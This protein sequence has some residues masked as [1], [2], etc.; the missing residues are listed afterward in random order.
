M[1][2][3]DRGRKS[4]LLTVPEF[5]KLLGVGETGS[6]TLECLEIVDH[7]GSQGQKYFGR[8]ATLGSWIW[9]A[10]RQHLD[11][12][13]RRSKTVLRTEGAIEKATKRRDY[14]RAQIELFKAGCRLA[15][16]RAEEQ[17]STCYRRLEELGLL[18]VERW[19]DNRGHSHVRMRSHPGVLKRDPEK[20]DVDKLP[21]ETND[22]GRSKP[23]DESAQTFR[24]RPEHFDDRKRRQRMWSI[25]SGI[26][27]ILEGEKSKATARRKAAQAPNP[28]SGYVPNPGSGDT[29]SRV[30]L[31]ANPG[32]NTFTNPYQTPVSKTVPAPLRGAAPSFAYPE[33]KPKDQ[34]STDVIVFERIKI[35]TDLTPNQMLTELGDV[36]G[37]LEGPDFEFTEHRGVLLVRRGLEH[38]V[39]ETLYN[40][41]PDL[42][43]FT[44]LHE[45]RVLVSR[46]HRA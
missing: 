7:M 30:G 26:V 11:S 19:K 34:D 21:L 3:A 1:P 12:L 36:C 45:G 35:P 16:G 37:F 41:P 15:R 5:S 44:V 43:S 6:R 31:G 8:L 2:P 23:W 38:E 24:R 22:R 25:P 32:S 13:L 14:Y 17:A 33:G 46:E 29:K 42:P 28:G 20:T 9:D 27:A 10:R 4:K 39:R 18:R 40:I